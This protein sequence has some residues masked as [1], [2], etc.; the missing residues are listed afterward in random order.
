MR[1]SS[2]VTGSDRPVGLFGGRFDP[3]HRAHLHIAQAAVKQLGLD[4]LRWIVA[5]QPVHKLAVAPAWARLEMV[6][7]AINDCNDPKM[8]VDP[9][10]IE[11][12]NSAQSNYTVDTVASLKKDFP[13]RRMI[14]ILGEDQLKQ[15]HSWSRW[16]QL[17]KEVEFAVCKRPE[18][19]APHPSLPKELENSLVIHTLRVDPDPISSS[20]IRKRISLNQSLKGFVPDRVEDYIATHALYKN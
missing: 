12:A 18:T 7:L 11:A 16:Q 14:W 19:G 3:I 5:G 1:P 9:R 2:P 8:V 6:R 17:T 13:N 4:H 10:E 20:M 15:L